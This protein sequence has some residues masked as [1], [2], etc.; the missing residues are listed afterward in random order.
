MPH[1][2]RTAV[3]LLVSLASIGH[4]TARALPQVYQYPSS[5]SSGGSTP[6]DNSMN[7]ESD[8]ST[9]LQ[10]NPN[11]NIIA[12]NVNGN[13]NANTNLLMDS[14][15]AEGGSSPSASADITGNNI[16]P[17]QENSVQNYGT[18]LIEEDGKDNEAFANAGF[19]PDQEALAE[20]LEG[21][22]GRQQ[23]DVAPES[24]PRVQFPGGRVQPPAQNPAEGQESVN[25]ARATEILQSGQRT[26]NESES[27]ADNQII[28]EEEVPRYQPQPL[29]DIADFPSLDPDEVVTPANEVDQ[30]GNVIRILTTKPDIDREFKLK[31]ESDAPDAATIERNKRLAKEEKDRLA[32]K[33][34]PSERKFLPDDQLPPGAE[35]EADYSLRN[36]RGERINEYGLL[37]DENGEPIPESDDPYANERYEEENIEDFGEQYDAENIRNPDD[38][39]GEASL[40]ITELDTDAG[41]QSDLDDVDPNETYAQR[42]KPRR[43]R[44]EKD[45][46]P[47]LKTGG[48]ADKPFVVGD[49]TQTGG[50]SNI[51]RYP[52]DKFRK[53][54]NQRSPNSTRRQ[55]NMPKTGLV[56]KPGPRTYKSSQENSNPYSFLEQPYN[57]IP[58]QAIEDSMIA[59]AKLDSQ[60]RSN[61]PNQQ[62]SQQAQAPT[63]RP[64]MSIDEVMQLIAYQ[65]AQ[66]A[67]AREQEN[68]SGIDSAQQTMMSLAEAGGIPSRKRTNTQGTQINQNIDQTLYDLANQAF[69][70]NLQLSSINSLAMPRGNNPDFDFNNYAGGQAQNFNPGLSFGYDESL[71]LNSGQEET[72]PSEMLQGTNAPAGDYVTKTAANMTEAELIDF[73]TNL[74]IPVG[75]GNDLYSEEY[76]RQLVAQ[77]M[78]DDV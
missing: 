25:P 11:E 35:V 49:Y 23:F 24:L 68:Q 69:Q 38:R 16:N 7:I 34:S 32:G 62:V 52:S 39:S 18:M 70:G 9:N 45:L 21:T 19:E 37:L 54:D 6:D 42:V 65:T 60:R 61:N 1:M 29:I 76:L 67:A 75:I 4:V 56:K 41:D 63:I 12:G 15:I 58:P 74:D 43:Q 44:F 59:Q 78:G 47:Y 73:L 51:A 46:K 53:T 30:D 14:D 2:A 26:P 10:L 28:E 50:R 36:E 27:A 8:T 22:G 33:A 13:A 72:L 5:G 17:T 3:L 31:Q 64:N 48:R 57:D 77:L 55:K 40:L 71:N 20:D 66:E